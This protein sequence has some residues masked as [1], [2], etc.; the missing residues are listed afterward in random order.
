[1]NPEIV[2]SIDP[3]TEKSGVAI[4]HDGEIHNLLS[5]S[6]PELTEYIRMTNAHYVIE[7]VEAIKTIYKRN[8]KANTGSG[9]QVA[10]S[11]GLVKATG[12]H[13]IEFLN[14]YGRSHTK[15]KPIKGNWGTMKTDPGKRALAQRLGWTKGSNKDT[16]SA[17]F[18]GWRYHQ[19]KQA[20]LL[21]KA[22]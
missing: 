8:R 7:D 12:R 5:M 19:L 13:L 16:R 10:Q 6:M 17:A 3:G 21:E 18:F 2:V 4:F 15:L 9:L 14:W 1:M 22:A 11:V 20:G